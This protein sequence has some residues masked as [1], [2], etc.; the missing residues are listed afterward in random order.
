MLASECERVPVCRQQLDQK[1]SCQSKIS[2][3][4]QT[5]PTLTVWILSLAFQGEGSWHELAKCNVIEKGKTL[6]WWRDV[7]SM[8]H[9]CD[10]I[11]MR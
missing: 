11:I 2:S 3:T 10:I 6:V 7:I 9:W 1:P 4:F 8:R 5:G